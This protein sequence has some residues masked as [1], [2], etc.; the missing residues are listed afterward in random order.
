M[1]APTTRPDASGF[2]DLDRDACLRLLA[3]RMVGRVVYTD[4]ALPAAQPVNYILDDEEVLFRTGSAGKLAAA[5]QGVVVAFQVDDID[6]ATRTGWS[7]LGVGESYEVVD[8]RRLAELAD[9][10][11]TWAPLPSDHVVCI[12]MQILTGRELVR[13]AAVPAG[14]ARRATS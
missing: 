4:G 1:A 11:V 2:R 14:P 10:L 8:P 6:P 5:T 13:G 12:P 7:V 9:R 3:A